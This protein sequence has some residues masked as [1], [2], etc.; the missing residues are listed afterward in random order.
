MKKGISSL[1]LFKN[2]YKKIRNTYFLEH[3]CWLLFLQGKNN[4]KE[5]LKCVLHTALIS[6]ASFNQ[7]KYKRK[8]FSLK[9]VRSEGTKW[10]IQYL[11]KLKMQLLS[12]VFGFRYQIYGKNKNKKFKPEAD[13]K[14]V[15]SASAVLSG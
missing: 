5:E 10:N 13:L 8:Q 11:L 3:F 4:K 14:P 6:N 1:V 2:F 15:K 12:F 7:N 9:S